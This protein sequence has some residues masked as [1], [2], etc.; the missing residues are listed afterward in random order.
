MENISVCGPDHL[1]LTA[2]VPLNQHPVG[3]YLASLSPGSVV[4]MRQSLNTMA[5]LL[6]RGECDAITLDWSKLRYQHT[7][8]LKVVLRQKYSPSTVNKMLCALRRVLKEAVRLDLI[9]PQNYSHAVDLSNMRVQGKPRGRAL[10]RSEITRIMEVCQSDSPIDVRDTAII[11]ILRG[12]GLRRAEVVN[13]DLE[14]FD[15]TTGKV[16]VRLGKGGK[17]RMVYLPESA[18]A[19]VENWLK[20]RGEMPGP[21]LCPVNK[22]GNLQ[23]RRM[24]PDAVLK[25]LKKRALQAGVEEFSPHDFR[26]T[27]CSDLLDANV[28]IVTV[29]KLAGHASPV[30]TA[31]YDRRGEETKKRAVQNLEF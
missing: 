8:A 4:T 11:A 18:I 6:T 5:S 13:L 17:D 25:I 21:L 7:A 28:D 27:F 2:P 14:D 20:V 16:Q 15:P 10:T 31:K 23:M 1:G 19:L 30:T 26:R 22:G 3:V 29:Q 9:D 12:T 24:C